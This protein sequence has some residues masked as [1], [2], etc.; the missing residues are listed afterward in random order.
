MS[1][2]L[3]QHVTKN[4]T[5]KMNDSRDMLQKVEKRLF[6]T[7]ICHF[8]PNKIFLKN[9]AQSLFRM[10]RDLS[11]C[12]KSEKLNEP[13]F[14]KSSARTDGRAHKGQSIGPYLQRR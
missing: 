7:P 14:L 10:H 13:I 11:S 8:W 12:Q 2:H 1:P 3:Y 4:Q 9:R 6:F 5:N